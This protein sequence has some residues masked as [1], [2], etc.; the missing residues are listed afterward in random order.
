MAEAILRRPF[1]VSYT[2]PEL[3]E[4]L[5]DENGNIPKKALEQYREDLAHAVF[6]HDA[7]KVKGRYV[8]QGI[9]SKGNETANH[10]AAMLRN[11]IMGVIPKGS[12]KASIVE[13]WKRDPKKAQE[14]NLLRPEAVKDEAA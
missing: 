8:E 5:G 11:E 14:L 6:G 12:Y 7:K 1:P 9:G 10:F 13:I 2:E 3:K 4:L